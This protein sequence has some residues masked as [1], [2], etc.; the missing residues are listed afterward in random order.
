MIGRSNPN[1]CRIRSSRSGEQFMPQMLT[2]GSPVICG[3]ARS[4]T[5]TNAEIMIPMIGMKAKRR[6]MKRHMR[7]V[8]Y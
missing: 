4:I 1:S 6:T 3:N 2:A 7:G 8:S 5:N